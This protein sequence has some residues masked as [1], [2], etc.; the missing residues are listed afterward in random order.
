M[1]LVVIVGVV[2]DPDDN[3]GSTDGEP[4]IWD[5]AATELSMSWY[6]DEVDGWEHIAL[7]V[8]GHPED[9]VDDSADDREVATAVVL[10]PYLCDY[11]KANGNR[12]IAALNAEDPDAQREAIRTTLRASAKTRCE[13]RL[14]GWRPNCQSCG[15]RGI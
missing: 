10:M 11:W 6:C 7:W 14:I 3:E 13:R 9:L 5:I 12:E 8:L 4:G 2:G 15:R 1:V